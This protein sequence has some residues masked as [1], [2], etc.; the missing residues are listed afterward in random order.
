MVNCRKPIRADLVVRL[1]RAGLSIAKFWLSMQ[2][3]YDQ[4]EAEQVDQPEVER[5]AAA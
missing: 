3:A 2:S 4:W 5:I 1:E